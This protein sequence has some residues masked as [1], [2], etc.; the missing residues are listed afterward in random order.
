MGNGI[1]PYDSSN[2]RPQVR[3]I[4]KMVFLRGIVR[5]NTTW[6][7][8][9]SFI[10]IPAGFRPA[11]KSVFVMQGSGSCRYTINVLSN[12]R[13]VADRYSNTTTMNQTVPTGSWLNMCCSWIIN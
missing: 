3:R 10:T 2:D 7:T 9:D 5:N 1:E 12:G 4:G 13:V 8:H 6:Q 11:N